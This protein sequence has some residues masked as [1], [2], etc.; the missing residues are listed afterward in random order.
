MKILHFLFFCFLSDAAVQVEAKHNI[1]SAA[2]GGNASF[3]C[4]LTLSGSTKFF[5]KEKCERAEDILIK[6]DGSTAQSGR[7]SINY[8]DGSPGRGIVSATFTHMIKSDSGMYRCGLGRPSVPDSYFDFEVRVSNDLGKRV[9]FYRTQTEGDNITLGCSNTVYGQRKFFCKNQCK[10]EGE[11]L[12]DTSNDKSVSGRYSIE[13]TA[14]SLFGLYATITQL[15]KSDTGE[16]S[17]GYGNPLSPDSY[18]SVNVLV[19]HALNTTASPL[20]TATQMASNPP[21][22][23]LQTEATQSE[24]VTAR[25]STHCP[26]S[27]WLL[28]VRASLDGV[29]LMAVF[30]ML[31]YINKTRRNFGLNTRENDTNMELFAAHDSLDPTSEHKEPKRSG[32]KPTLH[33]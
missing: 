28:V 7:Y 31:C 13:Y 29:L 33:Y 3:V 14:G 16:Y 1:W 24:S 22:F 20:Q 26:D 30:L 8:K 32:T 17:C 6:T 25:V 27:S 4:Y 18:S 23:T 21:A 11:I 12:I 9:G 10:N 2:E 15:T 5:C 19:I